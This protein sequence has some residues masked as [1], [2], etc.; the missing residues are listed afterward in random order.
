MAF[1][2]DHLDQLDEFDKVTRYHLFCSCCAPKVWREE[3][4]WEYTP[5][6]FHIYYSRTTAGIA[7]GAER[8]HNIL[9][10][11]SRGSSQLVTKDKSGVYFHANSRSDDNA[12]E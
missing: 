8:L 10:T 2:Q 5:L 11:Y 4:G 1:S 7:K 12:I 9:D 3:F 6:G